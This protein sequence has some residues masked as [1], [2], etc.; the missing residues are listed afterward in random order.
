MIDWEALLVRQAE[1]D[2]RGVYEHIAFTLLEPGNA[3]KMAR[4]IYIRIRKLSSMPQSYAVYP[5]EP[6]KSRGLRHAN[7][8]KYIV[9]FVP[10]ESKRTVVVIR[11]V[12][13]GRDIDRVL[14]ET[15]DI[16]EV[17]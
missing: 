15:P 8:G 3:E 2:L 12:Y 10:V 7:V 11:I 16:N 17:I 1:A 6:W 5:K 14:E 13:G 9:F 4:R